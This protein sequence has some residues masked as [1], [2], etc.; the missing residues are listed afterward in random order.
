MGFSLTAEEGTVANSEW[1]DLDEIWVSAKNRNRWESVFIG[2]NGVSGNGDRGDSGYPL[3]IGNGSDI[4]ESKAG[5]L[6]RIG[7]SELFDNIS[8]GIFGGGRTNDDEV[9]AYLG[10]FSFDEVGNT[11]H[12]GENKNDA[13]Y[14]NCNTKTGKKRAGAIF[15]DGGFG[16]LVMSSE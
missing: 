16:E 2:N 10:G 1:F 5:F 11:A 7:G 13:G 9:G 15:F 3:Y 14:A 4:F 8:D 6:E 12:E